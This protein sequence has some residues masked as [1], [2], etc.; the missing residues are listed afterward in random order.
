MNELKLVGDVLQ[1]KGYPVARLEQGYTP[2]TVFE[3]FKDQVK[4]CGCPHD[5]T[6]EYKAQMVLKNAQN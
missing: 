4:N 1:Y 2:T 6:A 3:D 5:K